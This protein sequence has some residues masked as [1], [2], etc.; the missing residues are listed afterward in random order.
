MD[1]IK[2]KTL[3]HPNLKHAFCLRSGGVSPDPYKS[4]NCSYYVGDQNINVKKNHELILKTLNFEK[5]FSVKQVHSNKVVC[6]ED[7]FNKNAEIE[8][9]AIICK[10]FDLAIS[11]TTADCAPILIFDRKELIVGVAHA[12]WKGAVKGITDNLIEHFQM[13][14]SIIE[15]ILVAIGPC[16]GKDS[17]EVKSDMIKA[18]IKEDCLS[19]RFFINK[20]NSDFFDLCGYLVKKLQNK[21]LKFIDHIDEDTFKNSKKFF[22][23]RRETKKNNPTTG[24]MINIVGLTK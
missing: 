7:H 24:R 2:S 14:G 23:H 5:S 1:F 4:L 10:S 18:C 20:S 22:S 15:N 16:I 8:A 13:N 17:F 19:E 6:A 3:K 21:G 11:V 12:G 9:D